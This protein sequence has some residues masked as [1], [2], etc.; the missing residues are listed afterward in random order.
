MAAPHTPTPAAGGRKEA[1]M[2][3]TPS[4]PTSEVDAFLALRAEWKAA[5]CPSEHPY[6]VQARE[7]LAA[8]RSTFVEPLVTFG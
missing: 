2:A 6:M 8:P 4:T 7:A 1:T 3:T 5:G